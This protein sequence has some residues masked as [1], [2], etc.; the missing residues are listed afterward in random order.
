VLSFVGVRATCAIESG[1]GPRTI[2]HG[3]SR[4]G[5]RA[6]VRGPSLVPVRA[7]GVG[8]VPVRRRGPCL[9]RQGVER[10]VQALLGAWEEVPV[11]VEGEADRRVAGPGRHLLGVGAGGE[12]GNQRCWIP[13]E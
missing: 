1:Y 3:G 4:T 9:L 13:V 5:S 7:A 10:V 12:T 2:A 11:A 8:P 6:G